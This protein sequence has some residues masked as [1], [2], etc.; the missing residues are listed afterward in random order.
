M[1]AANGEGCKAYNSL[2]S[3][4][5][6]SGNEVTFYG[7]FLENNIRHWWSLLNILNSFLTKKLVLSVVSLTLFKT[8]QNFKE[9]ELCTTICPCFFPCCFCHSIMKP[10][11]TI[12]LTLSLAVRY[13]V[14]SSWDGRSTWLA[15][16]RI[17][18][19]KS[20]KDPVLG[21][22]SWKKGEK[23]HANSPYMK[24]IYHIHC[25]QS[26]LVISVLK[27]L[28][29][30]T[31]LQVDVTW[32]DISYHPSVFCGLRKQLGILT[33]KCGEELVL[34]KVFIIQVHTWCFV[35]FFW[36]NIICFCLQL[37]NVNMRL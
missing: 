16:S 28:S 22:Q 18:G 29:L 23:N 19:K 8:M 25:S 33:L 36:K 7:H 32:C 35:L 4:A 17:S 2:F 11:S 9:F 37:Y 5:T 27:E 24:L 12:K 14:G 15:K 30:T 3:K 13:L 20:F 26:C 1:T 21:T 34:S 6:S 10:S 31:N